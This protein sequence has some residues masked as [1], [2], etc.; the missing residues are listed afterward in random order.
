MSR[1]I[2]LSIDDELLAEIDRVAESTKESRSAIMRRAIREGLPLVQAGGGA[3]VV[4]LDSETSHD[5][6][7]VCKETGF[8]RAKVL[9]ETIRSGIQATYYRCMREKWIRAQEMNPKDQEAESM[10]H[11]LEESLFR[12]D[13]MGRELRTALR[14]RGAAITRFHDLLLHVT[15][16]WHRYKLIERLTEL[17]KN[18]FPIWGKGLSTAEIKWQVTMNE[19]YGVDAQL[20]EEEVK[21]RNEARR[22][23]DNTHRNTV[24][25]TLFNRP[26]PE[27]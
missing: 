24:E 26:F 9:I 3:D 17:R 23:E 8:S 6:E 15:E 16:A 7:T 4:K 18:S 13:P 25:D 1:N 20:P 27:K 19:K 21:A 22:L 14:Q 12:E 10:I 11:L 2:P 5:V